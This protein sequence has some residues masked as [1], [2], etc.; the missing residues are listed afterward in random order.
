MFQFYAVDARLSFSNV[1]TLQ[2][3]LEAMKGKEIA[4][5]RLEGIYE[6]R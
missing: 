4:R 1:V 3:L 5:G 6:R 2:G